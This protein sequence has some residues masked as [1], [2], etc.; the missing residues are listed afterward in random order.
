MGRLRKTLYYLVRG[1]VSSLAGSVAYLFGCCRQGWQRG[2]SPN[3]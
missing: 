1:H 2:S 3:Q